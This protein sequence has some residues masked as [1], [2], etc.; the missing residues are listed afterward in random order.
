MRYFLSSK[1]GKF[2]VSVCDPEYGQF[3]VDLH[4]CLCDLNCA[5]VFHSFR[6][7]QTFVEAWD[8]ETS[9]FVD[10]Q[11]LEVFVFN[12]GKNKVFRRS[13]P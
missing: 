7:A 9:G 12:V 11:I 10:I 2:V 13:L 8:F 6:L 1:L 3:F 5:A 4:G